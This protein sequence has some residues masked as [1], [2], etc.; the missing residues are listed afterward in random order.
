MKKRIIALIIALCL[1]LPM[2]LINAYAAEAVSESIVS[3]EVSE[4]EAGATTVTESEEAEEKA[5]ISDLISGE[6]IN[7]EKEKKNSSQND[8]KSEKENDKKD[9]NEEEKEEKEERRKYRVL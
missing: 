8:D 5:D 7:D 3:E 4:N 6:I 1:T 9:D 2:M